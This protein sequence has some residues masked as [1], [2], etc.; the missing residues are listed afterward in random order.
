M[1]ERKI[2]VGKIE[3]AAPGKIK[4]FKL[5]FRNAILV[6]TDTGPKA[7]YDFCT[8]QGGQ[9]KLDDNCLRCLRHGAMFE[10]GSGARRAGEAPEGS[11]LAEIPLLIEGQDLF[12]LWQL[13]E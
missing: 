9:L 13:P 4:R 5:G 1:E 11:F 10:V 3:E 2:F 12:A 8:H 6:H 7:Y